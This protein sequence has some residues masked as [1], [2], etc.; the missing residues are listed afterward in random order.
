MGNATAGLLL[1]LSLFA[2]G[3]GAPDPARASD[4]FLRHTATVDVV[5]EVGPSVVNITTERITQSP[6]PFGR[7]RALDPR[8]D[9]FFRNFFEYLFLRSTCLM[10]KV[11]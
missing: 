10:S 2:W 5:R 8:F 1:S 9:S 6:N 3:L 11:L 4:P 7:R